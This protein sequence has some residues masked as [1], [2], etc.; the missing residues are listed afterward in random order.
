MHDQQMK[1]ALLPEGTKIVHD[2]KLNTRFAT[3]HVGDK[4]YN[5]ADVA[6][7]KARVPANVRKFVRE[8]VNA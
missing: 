4:A 1:T 5:V 2:T 3:V 8:W 6:D 7:G